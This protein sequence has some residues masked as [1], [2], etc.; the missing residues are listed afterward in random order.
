MPVEIPTFDAPEKYEQY[1]LNVEARAPEKAQEARRLAVKLRATRDGAK[2]D[3]ERECLEAIYAYEW[4]LFKK[5]GKRQRASY[6]WRMVDERGIIP[7]VEHAVTRPK[8]TA[9]YRGLEAEGMLD[10]AFEAV[11]LRHK[12]VFSAAAVKKS[13]ER[14]AEWRSSGGG[15]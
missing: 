9:G 4:T 11:V 12:D 14:L 7:A 5:H 10:M 15:G 6:T 8:E 2:S 13:Q 1:A 3:V